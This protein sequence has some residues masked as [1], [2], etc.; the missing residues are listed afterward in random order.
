MQEI[1]ASVAELVRLS[2]ERRL[3]ISSPTDFLIE[4]FEQK[5][6]LTFSDDFK[7][8]LKNA[9]T[10]IYGHIEPLTIT[11]DYEDR[12]SLAKALRE[13]K[14]L[15]VP[16]QWVPICIDNGDYYCL[17]KLGVVHFWTA[18]GVSKESWANLA[19]WIREVWVGEA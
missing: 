5:N 2:E 13:A 15:G 7:Y 11:N 10:I 3:R 9:S 18:D 6:S 19:L 16:E 17:D 8:F 14:S 4:K 12:I 1:E